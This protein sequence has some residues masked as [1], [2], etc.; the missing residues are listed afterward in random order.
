MFNS[1][2][3]PVT[4][5]EDTNI[6]LLQMNTLGYKK[7]AITCSR[8]SLRPGTPTVLRLITKQPLS[9]SDSLGAEGPD[10]PM[11][12]GPQE[13]LGSSWE[14]TPWGPGLWSFPSWINSW[15]LPG[16]RSPLGG[17]LTLLVMGRGLGPR[18]ETAHL[19][20]C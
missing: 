16:K 3:L 5:E 20:S 7:N 4:P 17:V 11:E 1:L 13:S 9:L 12:G 2:T 15:S 8:L 6:I 19:G 14:Q 18:Q 10:Q